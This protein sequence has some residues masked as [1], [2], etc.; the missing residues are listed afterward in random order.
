MQNRNIRVAVVLVGTLACA[1]AQWLNY[2][3]SR[4]PRTKDGKPNLSAPAPRMNDKLDLSG[5]WRVEPE[6]EA[7]WNRVLGPHGLDLQIDL[8]YASKYAVNI[9]ADFK[10]GDEPVRSVAV[11]PPSRKGEANLCLPDSIPLYGLVMPLKIIQAPTELV[12]LTETKSPPRQIY[13]DGRNL[14]NDPQPSW[15]GYSVGKWQG[16]TLVVDTIG[17][18]DAPLD[19]FQHPRSES[20]RITEQFRRRDFGHMDLT[21]TFEDQKNYTRPF[22]VKVGLQLIPDSDIQEY[23]CADN[24]R[25]RGHVEK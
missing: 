4:T 11:E 2:P 25:D 5:V 22:T 20:M 3:E 6:S 14:P 13:T 19:A 1:Q 18:R 17:F 8:Q 9:L 7:E 15:M 16:D 23:V 21:T 24:E 10:P 12:V